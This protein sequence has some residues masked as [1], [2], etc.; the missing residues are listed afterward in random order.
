MMPLPGLFL[1][2]GLGIQSLPPGPG[3]A[4]SSSH[5]LEISLVGRPAPDFELESVDGKPLRLS[6]LRGRAV[7]LNFW[8][9]W[10]AA[11]RVE[12]PWLIDLDRRHAERLQVVAVS[13]DEP[14]ARG[15]AEFVRA[16]RV[17][18]PILLGGKSIAAQYG[19]VR[20]LPQTFLIDRSG[21]V[22]ES[23]TGIESR[24]ALEERVR[25]VLKRIARGQN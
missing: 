22:V 13:M 4:A 1:V 5:E 7:L 25:R 23:L 19:G 3:G 16:N 20:W 11:C 14:G 15:I 18:Y 9:T 2:L 12:T 8:A 10:C 21:K 17:T 6:S 24:N